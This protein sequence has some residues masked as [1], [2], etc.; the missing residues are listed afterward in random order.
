MSYIHFYIHLTSVRGEPLPAAGIHYPLLADAHP[1][2]AVTRAYGV[3]DEQAGSSSR[4][5]FVL[6]ERG[7]ICW[8]QTYPATVNPG[9][10]GILTAL[11]SMG[12]EEVGA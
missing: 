7:I 12:G 10:D 6:D 2:G 5:L 4:T 8:S 1:H 3:F 9:V 11:E